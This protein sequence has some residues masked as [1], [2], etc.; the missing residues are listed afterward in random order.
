MT[1]R[2]RFGSIRKLPSRRWQATYSAPNGKRITAPHTFRARLDAEAWLADRRREIDAKLWNPHAHQPQRTLFGVY[3]ARWLTNRDLRPR[4]REGYE[5]ILRTHLV[6]T[7]GD[8]QLAAITPGDVRDWHSAL[9]PGK[10][11]MRAQ[12]YAVLRAILSTAAADELIPSNPCRIRG[13]GQTQ[14]VHKIRPATVAELDALTA[15]MPDRLKL[16]VPLASWCALRFGEMIELR[17]GDVD[18]FDEVIRVR[19]AAVKLVGAPGGHI[20]GPPKS[21]AGV[22]DVSIPPHMLVLVEQHLADHVGPQRDSLLFP[23][24]PGGT[25]HLSLASM[26]RVWTVARSSCGRPDLRW[27]DLRHTGLVMA[28]VAGAT[29]AELMARAGHSTVG[30]SMRYQHAA[31]SRDREIASLLSKLADST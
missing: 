30:A 16:A 6:P 18:L 28:A 7:F 2:R 12:C 11:A 20:V 22:R 25:H 23:S 1:T 3:A 15:A 24:V 8:M 27:H 17:R 14:R 29:L 19:R 10:A 5:R 13:A 4:T 9:L 26:H 21:R 31:Q